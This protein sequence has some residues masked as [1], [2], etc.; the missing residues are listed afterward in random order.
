MP[1]SRIASIQ[2]WCG[3]MPASQATGMSGTSG[4]ATSVM[5]SSRI[6]ERSSAQVMRAISPCRDSRAASTAVIATA[7]AP[8]ACTSPATAK[9]PSM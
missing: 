1:A 4:S 2:T 6:A 5:E 7:A 9:A 3:L 8:A